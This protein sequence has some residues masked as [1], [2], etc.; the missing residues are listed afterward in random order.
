MAYRNAI[1]KYNNGEGALLCNKC[2]VV[3]E[4]GCDHEDKE[5]TCPGC[6]SECAC[7]GSKNTMQRVE[8]FHDP[9]I[10]DVIVTHCLAKKCGMSTYSELDIGKTYEEGVHYNRKKKKA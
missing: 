1:V 2:M 4:T 7:C 6:R 8:P 10:G 9:K 5:H 3:L